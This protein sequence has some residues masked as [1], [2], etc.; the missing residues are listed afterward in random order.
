M[1][2]V[3]KMLRKE[4]FNVRVDCLVEDDFGNWILF[5]DWTPDDAEDFIEEQNDDTD[6]DSLIGGWWI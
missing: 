4:C 6:L 3:E 1:N 2:E 5:N